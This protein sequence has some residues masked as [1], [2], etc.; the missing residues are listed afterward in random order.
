MSKEKGRSS[1]PPLV[2][3][4]LKEQRHRWRNGERILVETFLKQL[5]QTLSAE[6]GI[7]LDLIYQEIVLREEVGDQ[8]HQ[9]EYLQRFPHLKVELSL[10]FEVDRGLDWEIA[11][12]GTDAP[13]LMG[14][15][16]SSSL[17][18]VDGSA[19]TSELTLSTPPGQ[20]PLPGKST[21][22][23]ALAGYAIDRI[24][25][26][27]LTGVVY[28]ARQLQQDR[29]VAV[30]VVLA[31]VRQPAQMLARLCAE[32]ARL[33][34]LHHPNLCP[35]HEIGM[36][37]G[38][39]F[40]A[41]ERVENSLAR[42]VIDATP[43]QAAEWLQTL[44]T[45]IH[46]IHG[47]GIAH[48]N[49]TLDNV[50]VSFNGILKITDI[51]VAIYPRLQKCWPSAEPL[52]PR[53]DVNALGVILYTL[54]VGTAP[55]AE[56]TPPSK[57]RPAV[58]EELDAICMRCFDADP[59]KYANA[60]ELADELAAYLAGKPVKVRRSGFAKGLLGWFRRKQP[61]VTIPRPMPAPTD[62]AMLPVVCRLLRNSTRDDVVRHVG[63]TA[64]W[65]TGADSVIVFLVD[66][67][68]K[69][70][71]ATL[72]GGEATEELRLALDAG[73]PGEVAKTGQAVLMG[74]ARS[75]S[76]F[77]PIVDRR[78]GAK[79]RTLLAM[80]IITVES[81]VLGVVQAINKR[82]GAFTQADVDAMSA[83]LT[84][85]AVALERAT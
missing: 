82:D 48:G 77:D 9:D 85:A 40:I 4:I 45:T 83:L 20:Q 71:V 56:I 52:D 80:P 75:D 2:G 15:L 73:V 35:I 21:P 84:G 49:L 78:T 42:N 63:E 5:P 13:T 44:A 53:V 41:Q 33:G 16:G 12:D 36:D 79:T 61:G 54:L 57:V 37:A 3:A 7:L 1:P 30:K 58:P 70:L 14:P 23:P 64:A 81:V 34:E 6:P 67:E 51:G 72:V 27:G 22:P 17:P 38:R 29:S 19:G 32:S 62:D 8:P 18:R 47:Q 65:L 76:S 43:L 10:Q 39:I 59:D 46:D 66:R 50:L 24:L 69:E 26:R 60:G 11:S 55:K 31:G 68:R 74:D 28:K 25:G